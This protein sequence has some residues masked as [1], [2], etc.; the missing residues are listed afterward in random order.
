MRGLS[1]RFARRRRRAEPASTAGRPG[2]RDRRRRRGAR[3][4]RRRHAPGE[5]VG[6]PW[7]GHTC[8]VCAFCPIGKTRTCA[9]RRSSPGMDA[10]AASRRTLSPKP[11]TAPPARRPLPI[12]SPPRPL[13]CAGLIGWRSLRMAGPGIRELGLYGFGAAAHLVAQVAQPRGPRA[14]HAFTRPGDVQAQAFARD[15]S[16]PCGRAVRTSAP[17]TVLDAAILFAPAGALVPAALP[18]R[19]GRA[20]GSS[21]AAST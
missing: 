5:R 16:A 10:T 20:A 11:R 8:G 6:V 1:H 2:S 9:T 17:P 4:E 14:C 3:H 21:A 19:S 12:R 18:L 15:P 13:L 7:L